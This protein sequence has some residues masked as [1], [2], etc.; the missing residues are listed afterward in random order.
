M[1]SLHQTGRILAL[2]E[3]IEEEIRKHTAKCGKEAI[4][5]IQ[6]KYQLIEL[7]MGERDDYRVPSD[8][9]ISK[10]VQSR[11]EE[12]AAFV[13]R[14]RFT[15][16]HARAALGR[17]IEESPPNAYKDQQFK[18]SAIWE[19]VLELG[20]EGNVDFVTEDKAFFRDEN[21]SQGLADN[22]KAD[23]QRVSGTIKVHYGLGEYLRTVKAEQSPLNHQEIAESIDQ[24]IR[25]HLIVKA[26]DKGYQLGGLSEFAISAYLTEKPNIIAVKFTL[27][28]GTLGVRLPESLEEVEAKEVF[29]GDCTYRLAEKSALEIEPQNIYLVNSSGQKVPAF[30]EI[31][32]RGA[33]GIGRGTVTYTLR[34]PIEE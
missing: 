14:T 21:P 5:A 32:L 2:P 26:I 31:F 17:V 4:E 25:P 18:D 24:Q 3:V 34:K 20:K 23:C 22:L 29:E 15:L 28:Y 12:L 7:L 9:E 1:Y 6:K 27:Y 13:V 10:R 8:A 19:A 11:L 30:G 33:G 16:E